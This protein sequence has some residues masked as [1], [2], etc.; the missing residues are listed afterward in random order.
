MPDTMTEPTLTSSSPPPRAEFTILQRVYGVPLVGASLDKLDAILTSNGLLARPY[1]AAKGISA[2]AYGYL[3]P[4][5]ARLAPLIVRAD[6]LAN[7][8]F[9]IVESRFPY[10][11]HVK[12]EEVRERRTSLV[13]AAHKTFD[14]RVRQ[15]ALHVVEGVDQRFA[16]VIDYVEG[17]VKPRAN[18]AAG[19]A[20]ENSD[21][22][23]EET[24]YQ[25]QR[26]LALSKALTE[27]IA[28]Y[29]SAQL[30]QLQEKSPLVDRSVNQIQEISDGM[31]AQ[32]QAAQQS[33]ADLASS[34]QRSASGVQGQLKDT[35]AET[36]N[37]LAE[38]VRELQGVM[39]TEGLPLRE[40][41]DRVAAITTARVNPL[42]EKVRAVMNSTARSA[43]VPAA[44]SGANGN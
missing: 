17:Q 37:G 36:S 1:A 18:K 31:I 32:L 42:L 3:Q 16:P 20:H 40:R 30:N 39:T 34:L 27:R 24:T 13:D 33:T 43:N 29:P 11:F 9:D 2:A 6:G 5:E 35:L 38:T 22:A 4:I 7:R 41:A 15:P 25:Y 23:L 12:P 8:V 28:S 44:T 19:A 21:A 10:P 14:E 26:A